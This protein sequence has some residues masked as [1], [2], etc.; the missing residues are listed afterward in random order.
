MEWEKIVLQG[1][2]SLEG[3]AITE[4]LDGVGAGEGGGKVNVALYIYKGR[5]HDIVIFIQQ[6]DGGAG[7][8]RAGRQCVTI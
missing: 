6:L 1:D 5:E 4:D 3:L 8:A 2:F 7:C